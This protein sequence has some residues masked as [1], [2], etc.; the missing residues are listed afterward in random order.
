VFGD[1]LETI[2]KNCIFDLCGVKDFYRRT[3]NIVV[4]STVQQR[5][6]WLQEVKTIISKRIIL[7]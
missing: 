1:P 6:E 7:S 4:T 2:W 3:F 5:E